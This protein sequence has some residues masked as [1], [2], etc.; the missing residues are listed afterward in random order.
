M[1]RDRVGRSPTP[2]QAA[3]GHEERQRIE[4]AFDQLPED[5]R[6]IITLIR[7][8]KLSHKEA[9]ERTGRSEQASRALLRRALLALSWILTGHQ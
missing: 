5:Y 9:G 3:I 7:I 2:S 1:R 6:E 8:A 4:A